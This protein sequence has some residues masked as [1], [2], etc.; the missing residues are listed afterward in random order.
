MIQIALDHI[1]SGAVE[2]QRPAGMWVDLDQGRVAKSSH[3]ET[4]GLAASTCAEFK[5][6]RH[7]PSVFNSPSDAGRVCGTIDATPK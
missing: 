2:A 7:A 6:G 5:N 4:Q 3:L 1:P